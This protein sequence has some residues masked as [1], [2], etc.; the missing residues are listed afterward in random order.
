VLSFILLQ[1]FLNIYEIYIRINLILIFYKETHALH[2]EVAFYAPR[3]SST[4]E[5]NNIIFFAIVITHYY[6]YYY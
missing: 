4:S 1:I 5:N 3:P 2:S 6:Y